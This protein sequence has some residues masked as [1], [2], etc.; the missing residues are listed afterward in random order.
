MSSRTE[1]TYV[2]LD[3]CSDEGGDAV[4][5]AEVRDVTDAETSEVEAAA[6]VLVGNVGTE[7]VTRW[8]VEGTLIKLV[9]PIGDDRSGSCGGNS[10]DRREEGEGGREDG[11]GGE[12]AHCEGSVHLRRGRFW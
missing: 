1:G 12:E 2:G 5:A 11:K 9:G 8:N 4:V 6:V 10:S 3:Q 7:L